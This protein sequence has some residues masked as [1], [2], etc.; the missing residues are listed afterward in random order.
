MSGRLVSWLRILSVGEDP[1]CDDGTNRTLWSYGSGENVV[2]LRPGYDPPLNVNSEGKS[3]E[4]SCKA[5]S[6]RSRNFGPIFRHAV[7][8]GEDNL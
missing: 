8:S 6:S 1:P 5:V 4:I 7:I 3:F 2:P